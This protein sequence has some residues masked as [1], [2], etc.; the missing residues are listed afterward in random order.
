MFFQSWKYKSIASENTN[1]SANYLIFDCLVN[2]SMSAKW[3]W[4]S[5]YS[6]NVYL[7]L[8]NSNWNDRNSWGYSRMGKCHCNASAR[9][10][11]GNWM[12]M[13]FLNE[14][15]NDRV[16][17]S[18]QSISIS[19][20]RIQLIASWRSETERSDSREWLNGIPHLARASRPK[21]PQNRW[22][23]KFKNEKYFKAT[24]STLSPAPEKHPLI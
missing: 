12:Q 15:R 24:K 5:V 8:I 10:R 18:Y 11:F 3:Q 20:A 17:V 9:Q 21:F 16:G 13:A 1:F 19:W 4:E 22:I 6:L 23:V 7:F 2:G 14:N